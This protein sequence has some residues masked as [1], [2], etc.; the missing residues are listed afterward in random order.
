MGP[1]IR[2]QAEKY[3]VQFLDGLFLTHAHADHI[4][5][6]GH[7]PA[8]MHY[9]HGKNLPI[10]A[11]RLTRKEVEK[12]W[13]YLFDPKINVEYWGEGRPFFSEIIPYYPLKIGSFEILPFIQ[14]HSA[15]M[16]SVGIRVGNFAYCTDVRSFPEKSF[17]LLQDL[18]VFVVDCN[19]EFDTDKSH[20]YLEQSIHWAKK[21]NPKRTYL[22]HLDHTMDYDLISKK[23]PENVYLAYDGLTIEL[24]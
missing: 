7:L 5:G 17:N 12:K 10:Y 6:M 2:E 23:L 22:T 8:M 16:E 24:D 20:S 15:N 9:Y 14:N 21:L 1:D 3:N 18:E 11:D 19:N 4:S 13:W